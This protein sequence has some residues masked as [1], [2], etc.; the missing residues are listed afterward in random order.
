MATT[1][2]FPTIWGFRF[3]SSTF[4]PTYRPKYFSARKAVTVPTFEPN[5]S[6]LQE[7]LVIQKN[8][9]CGQSW[10]RLSIRFTSTSVAMRV[11][12]IWKSYSIATTY[13]ILKLKNTSM[14]FF[15]LV[16]TVTKLMSQDRPG[17]FHWV[18][19]TG[20]LTISS[21]LITFPL[22]ISVFVTSWTLPLD[23]Q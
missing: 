3:K 18:P 6:V 8:S 20:H 23:I 16:V 19:W 10:K 12:T 15:L 1:W 4:I 2:R 7:L 9:D 5:C 11:W 13:G 14:E 21:V 22:A 17:K